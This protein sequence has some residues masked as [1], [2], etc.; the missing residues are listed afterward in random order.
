MQIGI[1]FNLLKKLRYKAQL[2]LL[3]AQHGLKLAM[4]VRF[5][6]IQSIDSYVL[7]I[8]Q[9]IKK[10]YF[11]MSLLAEILDECISYKCSIVVG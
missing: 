9:L 11:I 6:F 5:A 2:F 3:V 4:L 1:L 10:P 8:A 7:K